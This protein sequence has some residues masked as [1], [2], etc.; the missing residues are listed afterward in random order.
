[1]KKTFLCSLL[2]VSLVIGAQ[3]Q[4]D[5]SGALSGTLGPGTYI[6]IGDI[7]VNSGQSITI[8]PGTEFLFNQ[9]TEFS[10]NGL[11]TAN[12][13]ANNGI[14]FKLNGGATSWYGIEFSTADDN[15][16]MSYCLV[17]ES[18]NSGDGGGFFIDS[19]DPTFNYC[20][21][22]GNSANVT[23]G[24]FYFSNSMAT[25]NYC[26]ISDNS[27][28]AFGGGIYC[29][30]SS[31]IFNNCL[32]ADNNSAF[33]GGGVCLQP[34]SYPVL[35]NCTI[36]GNTAMTNSGASVY[37]VA[38]STLNLFSSLI[39]GNGDGQGYQ[40]TFGV[41]SN[42]NTE[43]SQIE[44]FPGLSSP[45]D[46][47]LFIDPDNSDYRLIP[48]SRASD[49]G[50]PAFPYGNE[51][52]PNGDRINQ[53]A[54]GNTTDAAESQVT[55]YIPRDYYVFMGIP[56]AVPD[57][58][59]LTLFHDNVN[60]A[61]IGWPWWRTSRWDI[62]NGTYVRY[63][64]PDW[65]IDIGGEP[66]D[67]EPGLGFWFVENVV[68]N[69]YIDI[70]EEQM[71]GAPIQAD[72]LAQPLYPPENGYHGMN[73]MA[74][75]HP[76]VYDWRQT[77]ILDTVNGDSV[78]IA[79]AADSGW[80]SGYG[81]IWR[82]I[83]YEWQPVEFA[84]SA[85]FE[86]SDVD[87]WKGVLVE[88]LDE[89][90]DLDILYKPRWLW[91]DFITPN[92]ANWAL[93]LS[94]ACGVYEDEYNRAGVSNSSSDEYDSKDAIEYLPQ[95]DSFVQ[96]FFPHSEWGMTVEDFTYDYKDADFTEP[97]VW[98]FSVGAYNLAN[99]QV[100]I[101]WPNISDIDSE[102]EFR[103]EDETNG[104]IIE[105]MRQAGSYTFNTGSSGADLIYF[106]L[107]V[108][109]SIVGVEEN[110]SLTATDF[111]LH[112]AYPNPFNPETNITF[113]LE[114]SGM[115]SLKAYDI[116]GREIASLM[117]GSMNAGLHNVI[118]NASDLSSGVYFLRLE[119]NGQASSRKVMLLK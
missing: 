11:I 42:V 91:E 105:D 80:V 44:G 67:Y 36:A 53:G 119:S 113:G 52:E 55:L 70:V 54:Y 104:I 72:Y 18:G 22:T 83:K 47:V 33:S 111:G 76:Y 89:T 116:L 63:G 28:G 94:A 68:D 51:P 13:T 101:S 35:T 64:E 1:M 19:C 14:E 59:V 24:G 5:I 27:A 46:D 6:V 30:S 93:Q 41:Y 102:Y 49:S 50:D 57:G 9:A 32:I 87:V 62:A 8:E 78:T 106:N 90:K 48:G 7:Y 73:M 112:S 118:W 98:D 38:P 81:Y 60:Y 37:Q 15:S 2:I 31:P 4:T 10:I 110:S 88:Q 99:Q 45:Y 3:A 103:L 114:K 20:T 79:A 25:L 82:T 34:G 23:G 97:K 56:V 21:V 107:T 117:N 43:N 92:D 74:N 77:K 109:E 96:L 26:E 85:T 16:V 17:T 39:W 115:V 95:S 58:D 66:P 71:Y 40:S 61:T 84:P 108:T 69:C 29:N 12:G 86:D 65:P 100:T 75:P